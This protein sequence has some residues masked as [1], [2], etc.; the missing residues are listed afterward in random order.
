MMGSNYTKEEKTKTMVREHRYFVVKYKDMLKYL[1]EDE[2]RKMC[3]LGGKIERGREKDGRGVMECVCV[4][5]DWQEYDDTWLAIARR[6][7]YE[8]GIISPIVS[9]VEQIKR[10]GHSAIEE[11]HER[12]P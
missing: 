12:K 3:D 2:Q 11:N 6:V 4:E 1:T 10:Y 7:D 5:K 9:G 8:N